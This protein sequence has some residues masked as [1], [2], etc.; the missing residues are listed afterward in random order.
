MISTL[1]STPVVDE[2]TVA[3]HLHVLCPI[4]QERINQ[5]QSFSRLLGRFGPKKNH[6]SISREEY[7]TSLCRP[8][9]DDWLVLLKETKRLSE[10]PESFLPKGTLL[11]VDISGA[12]AVLRIITLA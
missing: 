12:E 10:Q 9:V 6:A 5:N 3:E 8:N 4:I 11:V 2:T 7:G 1:P